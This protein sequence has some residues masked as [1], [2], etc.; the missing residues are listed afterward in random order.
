[1]KTKKLTLRQAWLHLA[2]LWD[3]PVVQSW[4]SPVVDIGRG[5]CP[6]LCSSVAD[7]LGVGLTETRT[8]KAMDKAIGEAMRE[9]DV[10]YGWGLNLAGAKQRAAFCRLQAKKCVAKRRKPRQARS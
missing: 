10:V 4:S 3:K 1:M 8:A 7:M 5:G 9:R 6:G 2:K